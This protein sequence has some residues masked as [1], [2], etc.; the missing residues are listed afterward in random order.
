MVLKFFLYVLVFRWKEKYY[1]ENVMLSLT[2]DSYIRLF[3]PEEKNKYSI[4]KCNK[5]VLY[6]HAHDTCQQGE[7]AAVYDMLGIT[8]CDATKLTHW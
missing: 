7:A 1:A 8:V 2:V 4:W 6:S 3:I 5:S